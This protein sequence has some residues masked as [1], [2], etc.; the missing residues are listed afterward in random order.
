MCKT[1]Y[2]EGL[3]FCHVILECPKCTGS[4]AHTI[5]AALQTGYHTDQRSLIFC[6]HFILIRIIVD[7]EPFPG[8]LGTAQ[9]TTL[10]HTLVVANPPCS[11]MFLRG[12]EAHTIILHHI[13]SRGSIAL[14]QYVDDTQLIL[15]F[16]PSETHIS[17]RISADLA[18]TLS[19]VAAE[20]KSCQN[21]AAVHPW[22]CM[23]MS[24]SYWKNSLTTHKALM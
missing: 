21:R 17:S 1:H 8:T 2:I 10:I 15:T 13:T 7:S 24:S 5:C 20:T 3:S 11:G 19:Y 6:K 9:S 18:D 22:R 4:H 16:P 12:R 14:L 23:T